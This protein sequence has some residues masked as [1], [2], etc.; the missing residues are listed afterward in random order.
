MTKTTKQSRASNQGIEL[1]IAWLLVLIL[2]FALIVFFGL[3]LLLLSVPPPIL[4][5]GFKFNL[6]LLVIS[7]LTFLYIRKFPTWLKRP[8]VQEDTRSTETIKTF[9]ERILGYCPTCKKET[10]FWHGERGALV[11]YSCGNSFI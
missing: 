8:K 2:N 4:N 6:A 7:I 9:E 10:E 1:A 11:C 5:I 3:N